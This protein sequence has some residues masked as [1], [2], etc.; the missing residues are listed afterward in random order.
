MKKRNLL[1]IGSAMLF[2]VVVN[3]QS[4][5]TITNST[6][7]A[8][9]T[10]TITV[11]SV[12]TNS[13]ALTEGINTTGSGGGD[14]FGIQARAVGGSNYNVG[15]YGLADNAGVT[16]VGVFGHSNSAVSSNYGVYGVAGGG[17]YNYAGYFDGDVYTT[18]SYLPSD[19]KLKRNIRTE[20]SV[21]EKIMQLRPVSYEY[22]FDELKYI[23]LPA[24]RQHGFVAQELQKVFPEAVKEI[25]HPVFEGNKL[26]RTE[27][28]TAVNYQALV[29]VLIKAVQEQ[30][31]MIDEL[32]KQVSELSNKK[33]TKKGGTAV[34]LADAMPNPVNTSTTIKY[35]IP[36]SIE[37]ASIEV[38]DA[39]GRKV[40]QFNNLRG[41]SQVVIASE[42][43]QAGTYVYSLVVGGKGVITNKF[44]VAKG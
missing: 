23:S 13:S 37:K 3:A 9:S 11:S 24:N 18:G 7:R 28:I 4:R 14:N 38:Y 29:P 33:I 6:G 43:L 1:F 2:S 19:L 21:L 15:V 39:A 26:V 32:K 34:Y 40:L 41:N 16:G 36:A 25:K 17:A 44:V 30:Q 10:P 42:Q 35:S 20:T 5:L 27:D 22:R 31:A 12:G 8:S